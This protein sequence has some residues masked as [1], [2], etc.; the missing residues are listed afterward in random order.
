MMSSSEASSSEAVHQKQP[1]QKLKIQDL[2]LQ[3]MFNGFK[4]NAEDWE[5]K[6]T[7][8]W[9]IFEGIGCISSKSVDNVQLYE[10]YNHLLHYS[11][12]SPLQDKKTALEYSSAGNNVPSQW[13]WI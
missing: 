3:K 8:I 6:A 1:H 13:E 2:I 4:S 12:V 11:T 5:Y 10:V 7:F 9:R